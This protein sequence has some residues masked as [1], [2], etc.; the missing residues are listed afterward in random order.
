MGV[1]LK[2]IIEKRPKMEG[3]SYRRIEKRKEKEIKQR[4]LKKR[5]KKE[6]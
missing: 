6:I 2:Q 3:S 5:F 1:V 4:D